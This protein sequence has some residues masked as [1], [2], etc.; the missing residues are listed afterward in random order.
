[1]IRDIRIVLPAPAMPFIHS[2]ALGDANQFLNSP[3][4]VNHTP[5]PGCKRFKALLWYLRGST[6]LTGQRKS[7][8]AWL[9]LSTISLSSLFWSSLLPL[10]SA[11]ISLTIDSA[12][13]RFSELSEV[14]ARFNV[15]L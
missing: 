8:T 12:R 13:R 10:T 1:M 4:S 5:V 3:L 11:L 2:F 15:D 7:R 14:K 6:D 9:S